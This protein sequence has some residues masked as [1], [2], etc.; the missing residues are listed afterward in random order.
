MQ[1]TSN[2]TYVHINPKNTGQFVSFCI[3]SSPLFA[4]WLPLSWPLGPLPIPYPTT[5]L[6]WKQ[7][8]TTSVINM[9][10]NVTKVERAVLYQ[11]LRTNR[12]TDNCHPF[13]NISWI[14]VNFTITKSITIS[15]VTMVT[16]CPTFAEHRQYSRGQQPINRDRPVDLCGAPSRLWGIS[17]QLFVHFHQSPKAVCASAMLK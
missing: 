13:F 14:L 16:Y 12:S 10:W 5:H 6:K 2:N 9:Q 1:A 11:N 8:V 15:A 4:D 7:W 17:V 3:T